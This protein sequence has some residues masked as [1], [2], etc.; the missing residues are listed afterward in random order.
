MPILPG[1][2]ML[3]PAGLLDE[4]LDGG[5]CV[6]WDGRALPDRARWYVA[7]T[8]PRQEKALAR[9]ALSRRIPFFLPQHARPTA[10]PRHAACSWIPLFTGY[11]FL[12]SDE[13]QRVEALQSNRIAACLR[14]PDQAGFLEDLRR[15]KRVLDS[16][17]SLYPEER[18]RPGSRVRIM[19]G[20]LAGLEGIVESRP[21]RSRF[22][23]A[24]DFLRQGVGIEV[25][26][27]ALEP[28]ES[29]ASA[30][31][32]TEHASSPNGFDARPAVA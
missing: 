18:I 13:P 23:V 20:P 6:D 3:Y 30:A 25:D 28:I 11:V 10:G 16:G 19:S 21:G 7:H 15:I 8:K 31:A 29:P 26:A 22:V 5:A 17:L 14:V 4:P 32:A 2:P 1:E 27:R 24:V 12:R 9:Y